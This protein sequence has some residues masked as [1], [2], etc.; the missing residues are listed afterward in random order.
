MKLKLDLG[1]FYAIWKG[2]RN[3]SGLP[4]ASGP[5]KQVTYGN[6]YVTTL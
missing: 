3:A 2:H 4:T 6:A 5:V 1:I